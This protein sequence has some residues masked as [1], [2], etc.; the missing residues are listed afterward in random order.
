[1]KIKSG[2]ARRSKM[3]QDE[4]NEAIASKKPKNEANESN[5]QFFSIT[6]KAP[7]YPSFGFVAP[8][9]KRGG[10]LAMVLQF[11]P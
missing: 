8:L 11:L 2:E 4:A 7:L 3:K 10:N 9:F 1:M 5:V 6:N